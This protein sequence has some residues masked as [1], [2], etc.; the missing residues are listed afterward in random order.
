MTRGTERLV[1]IGALLVVASIGLV[2][3]GTADV[4]DTKFGKHAESD[5]RKV[6]TGRHGEQ[7]EKA[8]GS[9]PPRATNAEELRKRLTGALMTNGR[10]DRFQ[11]LAWVLDEVTP[12]N[13]KEL[14]QEYIRMTLDDGRVHERELQFFMIRVGEVA[15]PQAISFFETNGQSEYV[16]NRRE[17]LRGW[18]AIDPEG[19]VAW[20]ESQPEN[21]PN[22]QLWPTLVGSVA[23]TNP[24]TAVAI[25]CGLSPDRQK[26]LVEPM[27]DSLIQLEGIHGAIRRLESLVHEV[28][29]GGDM[30][31]MHQLYY[32]SLRARA[33][34][35]DW[36]GSAYPE[37]ERSVPNLESL[38]PFFEKKEE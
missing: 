37:F 34:R 35:L 10:T 24:D 2:I 23:E 36:L 1:W 6:D 33:G 8:T 3:R 11:R 21:S 28:P 7:A 5:F 9:R 38:A 30:P 4:A 29:E 19:A 31:T 27:V 16:F 26:R 13:W 25:V 22:Q 18:S 12:E 32:Q 14:W 15:G 17:V 20:I